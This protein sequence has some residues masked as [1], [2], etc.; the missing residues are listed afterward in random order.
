MKGAKVQAAAQ[1]KQSFKVLITGQPT[2][3]NPEAKVKPHETKLDVQ[4]ASGVQSIANLNYPVTKTFTWAPDTCG[5]VN[6]QI[7]V[8]DVILTK[9]YSRAPRVPQFS[10]GLQ[11]RQNTPSRPRNSR[12]KRQPWT[13]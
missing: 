6:F 9:K 5:E 2:D 1:V 13:E 8:G 7:E 10:A 4:C 11:G 3:A 12:Q